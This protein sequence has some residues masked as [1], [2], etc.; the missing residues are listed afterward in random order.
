MLPFFHLVADSSS[1]DI[2]CMIVNTTASTGNDLIGTLPA[3]LSLFTGLKRF[4]APENS[5]RGD[6]D[7]AFGGIS[8][9]QTLALPDN[10]LTGTIPTGILEMNPDLSLL[11]IGGNQFGGTIPSSVAG[12]TKLTDLQLYGNSL[13]GTIPTDIGSL[14]LLGAFDKSMYFAL[15]SLHDVRLLSDPMTF[16]FCSEYRVTG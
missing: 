4:L 8:S 5:L 1:H 10:R 12:A 13:T 6:L 14:S 9:L 11:S 3:E 16:L 7:V 15:S 2:F